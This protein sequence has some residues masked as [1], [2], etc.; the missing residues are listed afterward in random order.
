MQLG[1]SNKYQRSRKTFGLSTIWHEGQ[2][3]ARL[4]KA[5]LAA[6]Q[7]RRALLGVFAAPLT[8]V[9][10]M[11]TSTLALSLLAGFLLAFENVNAILGEAR[12]QVVL[13][14]YLKDGVNQSALDELKKHIQQDPQIESVTYRS[15][16]EALHEF[17]ST[18]GEQA[19]LLDGLEAE[20]PLP[21]SLEIKFSEGSQADFQ[22]IA[23][24][25]RQHN[26][27]EGAHYNQGVL[28][29]IALLFDKANWLGT[30]GALLLLCMSAFIIANTISLALYAHRSEIEI[31]RLVGAT[32][33]FIRAPYLIEGAL[34]GF[35]GG[36]LGVVLVYCLTGAIGALFGPS[37][38]LTNLMPAWRS[39][40]VVS[41]FFVCLGG[42]LVGLG[43]SY[44]ALRKFRVD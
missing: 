2:H 39:L 28:H 35:L 20:N 32:D 16:K 22:Q 30:I 21:A 24:Q 11:L 9:L 13:S 38:T 43:G 14:L 4:S 8:A 7:L 5:G 34:Q 23:D 3:V 10:T 19:S 18:L 27:V 40:S 42:T 6:Q 17:R 1:I 44:L 26:L 31:M 15:K 41:I 29:H 33:G 36:C 37:L 12:G 25:Y